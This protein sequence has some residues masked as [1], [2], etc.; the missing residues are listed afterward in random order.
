MIMDEKKTKAKIVTALRRIWFYSAIRREAAKRA[1][2]GSFFRCMKCKGLHE[3]IQID[4][5]EPA[6][7]PKTGWI[8]YD[9]FIN[10]LLFCS[11]DNLMPLCASCHKKKTNKEKTHRATARKEK[12][13]S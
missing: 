13:S 3:K 11:V 10:R 9:S 6:I 4:H 5:I 1:K 12:K 7:D 2:E 8:G